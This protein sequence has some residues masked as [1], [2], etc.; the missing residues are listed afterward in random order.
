VSQTPTPQRRH[1]R[2]FR[3][4]LTTWFGLLV[5]GAV[6]LF[7]LGYLQF[8]VR[9]VLL[10]NAESQFNAACSQVEVTLLRTFRPAENL[11]KI[12]SQWA[13]APGFSIDRPER[14]NELFLPLLSQSPQ[15]TSVVAG[16]ETGEGWMLLELPDGRWR[17]RFTDLSHWGQEQ[18]FFDWFEGEAAVEKREI[19]DYD[20]RLRPWF[21]AAMAA[22][23]EGQPQWT[24]PYGF[25][26]TL[27][28]GI[29]VATRRT[30]PDGRQLALGLDIRL[31]DISSTSSTVKLGT[32][33]QLLVLTG[34]E[35]ILGLP[36]MLAG[37]TDLLLQPVDQLPLSR[38]QTGL[39]QWRE[40]G[41]PRDRILHFRAQGEPWL[42]TFKPFALGEQTL[43][44]ALFAPETDFIP[45][46]QQFGQALGVILVLVLGLT[47]WLARKQARRFSAPLESLVEAS[48][49]IAHLDFG[50]GPSPPVHYREFHRLV[51]A[52]DRMRAMLEEF[53][54]TVE[55]QAQHLRQALSEKDAILDNALVGIALVVERRIVQH[56]RRLAE[57]LG[58]AGE[59]LSGRSTEGL[60]LDRE[61]YLALGERIYQTFGRGESFDEELWVQCKEGRRI[62]AHLSGRA[63]DPGAPAAG[64][65]W[66]LADLTEQKTA[67]ERLHYLGHHDP[68]TGLANRHLLNDRLEHAILRA[69]REGEQL[70]LLFIDL[71]HFKM[72]N[73]TLGHSVGD[74]LLCAMAQRLAGQLRSSDTL[75][76]MGGDEFIILVEGVAEAGAL[77]QIAAKLV[78][79]FA[80]PVELEQ[81]QLY[82]TGSIGISL[83]PA[84]GLDAKTLIRNADA[85]MYQAKAQGR[86][87][88]HFYSAEMTRIALR[89]LEVE[90]YLRQG[91]KESWLELHFQPQVSLVDGSLVGAEALVRL[92]HPQLGPISPLEFIGLAE[93][94][95]LIFPLG[96][97]VIEESCRTWT[98]LAAQGLHLPRLAVNLSA[99]QLQRRDF[100]A[101]TTAILAA[102]GMP[103]GVLELEIT[104]SVF[105]ES[106]EALELL[107]A[108]GALGI[109]LALDDFGTGYSSLSY[110]KRLPFG[111]LKIDKSFIGDIGQSADSETLVRTIINLAATLGLEVIAEGV[112]TGE[113]VAFLLPA[114]CRNAQGYR[115]AK[116]LPK[117]EFEIWLRQRSAPTA[118]AY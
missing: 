13:I 40:A 92:R 47:L 10:L 57:I 30:L 36:R 37:R 99:K 96:E 7:T 74:Q 66:I 88:Y 118:A 28:P 43:W 82:V 26:T 12:A 34:E 25:F 83:Y 53:R 23:E 93:E 1:L 97:W 15:L 79:T 86:N 105:L 17:N 55:A 6:A 2:S 78:E 11:L 90:G 3:R 98:E 50:A 111:K 16:T 106:G 72:V 20:P 19:V 109:R 31:I 41:R 48:E 117:A 71:D 100:L 75:A 67:E 112:E 44:V 24:A 62:W 5:L 49:R 73:D 70:A 114:G 58:Y 102:C 69:Q 91:L 60:Y 4:S 65:V 95:G 89:R 22:A 59:D 39:S 77:V 51:Q 80:A 94:T 76:R 61:S 33:G 64:S 54:A 52:Q 9:P 101:N 32:Q 63:I 113:Q 29:T 87:T 42:A 81:R 8:G 84:D 38:M 110:L 103:A 68:L 108:L 21:Q 116:P 85:A 56:N 27:E 115:F 46:W 14:F 45:P 104:E 18:R 107:G 35:R